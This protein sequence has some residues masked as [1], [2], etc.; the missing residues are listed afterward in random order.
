[1][2][3]DESLVQ[4]TREALAGRDDVV[5]KRMFGGLTFMVRGNMCC[6]VGKMGMMVRVGP[7]QYQEALAKPGASVM[8]FTGR[9]MRGFVSVDPA[10]VGEDKV[11]GDWVAMGLRFVMTLPEK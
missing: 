6:G 2:A 4:R 8:D 9:E 3:Y 10:S 11:L 7:D 1:M 5:E